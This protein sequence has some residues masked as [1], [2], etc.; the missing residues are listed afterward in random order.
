MHELS[1]MMNLVTAAAD[2][3]EK[4]GVSKVL[5]LTVD[6]GEMTGILPKYLIY[7]FPEASKGTVCE[8]AELI[9]N[10]IPVTISCTDCGKDYHPEA[11]N[12]RSCPFCGSARGKIKNGRELSVSDIVCDMI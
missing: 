12:D 4:N 6:V 3:A 1:A 2:A 8:G 11:S 10:E 5:K 9:I 7:Y